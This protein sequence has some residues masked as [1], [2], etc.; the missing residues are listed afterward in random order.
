MGTIERK[1]IYI[2]IA[3]FIYCISG[4]QSPDKVRSTSGLGATIGSL[5]ELVYPESI[6]VEGYGLVGGLRGKGSMECPPQIREYLTRYIMAQ[7]PEDTIS[8]AES[9]IDSPN[10]AVVQIKA[11]VPVQDA[12]TKYFDVVVSALP[13]TQTTSLEGG[14]LF[15]SEMK[16]TGSF[17]VTTEILADAQGPVFMDK[18]GTSGIDK[19]KGFV[20]AGGKS[21]TDYKIML[22]VKKPGFEM[23]NNIRNRLNQRFGRDIAR[24]V[25][26]GRIEVTIPARYN[27]NRRKF[28]SLI[29]ALYLAET[30]EIAGKRINYHVKQIALSPLHYHRAIRKVKLLSRP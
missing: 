18:I 14:W 7:L 5:V 11:V 23:T 9:L 13:G 8:K 21:L 30:P 6:S 22:V 2:I 3:L 16:I 28:A 12:E 17:G 19:R 25:S 20:L 15:P 27:E 1:A 26:P 29:R 10:T 24:A 4:C